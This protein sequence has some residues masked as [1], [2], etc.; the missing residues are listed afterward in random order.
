M[1]RQNNWRNEHGIQSK[2]HILVSNWVS[3]YSNFANLP[4]SGKLIAHVDPILLNEN[5]FAIRHGINPLINCAIDPVF[6]LTKHW[7]P[8][9]IRPFLMDGKQYMMKD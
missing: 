2:L 8:R 3:L 5:I 1:R 7:T 4:T 9:G 6:V